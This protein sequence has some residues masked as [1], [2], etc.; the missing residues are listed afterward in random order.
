MGEAR[1]SLEEMPT[2]AH[3][4]ETDGPNRWI[5]VR[6]NANLADQND[7]LVRYAVDMVRQSYGEHRVVAAATKYL[8]PDELVAKT[9]DLEEV[10][11]G[12]RLGLPDPSAEERKPPQ[13]RNYRAE[14]TEILIRGV[15]ATHHAVRFPVSPQAGKTNPNQPILGFDGWGTVEFDGTLYFVLIQVKGTEVHESPPDVA[16]T[17]IAECKAM[18]TQIGV[19]AR[20][21]SILVSSM[22][23]SVVQGHL[24]A[25]LALL[26]AG[27]L[28]PMV[29]V[30]AIVRGLQEAHAHDLSTLRS[31]SRTFRADACW[32]VTLSLGVA[33]DEFGSVVT[34]R[35][36]AAT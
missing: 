30:P 19:I 8:E 10:V 17:L 35:A 16:A 9:F 4:Q 15:L 21:L 3:I 7:E 14:P 13:L 22:E 25:M 29:V 27:K 26:G 24:L 20:A 1:I 11:R 33:L 12:F 6:C 32:G 2:V 36:R 18:P 28:P 31:A 5:V 34:L 23:K